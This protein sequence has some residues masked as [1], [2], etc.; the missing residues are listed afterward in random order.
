MAGDIGK[1]GLEVERVRAVRRK[2]GAHGVGRRI[3]LADTRY[4]NVEPRGGKRLGDAEADAA[5][6]AGDDGDGTG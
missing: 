2:V 5:A 4:G 1:I 6:A 3:R